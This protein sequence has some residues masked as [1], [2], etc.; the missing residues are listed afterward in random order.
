[1]PAKTRIKGTSGGMPAKTKNP[2]DIRLDAC[3]TTIKGT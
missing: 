2:W 1:M 3:K